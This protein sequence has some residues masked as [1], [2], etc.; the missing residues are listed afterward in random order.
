MK[1]REKNISHNVAWR[2]GCVIGLPRNDLGFDSDG[3]R[4]VKSE[5]HVH[6]NG[7]YI[8]APSSNDLAVDGALN[9]TNQPTISHKQCDSASKVLVNSSIAMMNIRRKPRIEIKWL[10]L[11]FMKMQCCKIIIRHYDNHAIYPV[12]PYLSNRPT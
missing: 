10:S 9:T 3:D 8:G 7:Q 11:G 6:R 12:N 2:S 1:K 5:L 4:V